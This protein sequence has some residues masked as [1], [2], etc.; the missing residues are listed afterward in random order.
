M[1][2]MWSSRRRRQI[3]N[4]PDPMRSSDIARGVK[5]RGQQTTISVQGT[6]TG[7]LDDAGVALAVALVDVAVPSHVVVVYPGA[8]CWFV[9]V[10]DV[11]PKD[12]ELARWFII[13]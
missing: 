9:F 8:F 12:V 1:H 2:V 4:L 5:P 6:R 10:D 11:D 7:K 13:F 3:L